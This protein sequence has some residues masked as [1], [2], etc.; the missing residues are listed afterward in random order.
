MSGSPR[1]DYPTMK[2]YPNRFAITDVFGKEL[3]LKDVRNGMSVKI[4][5]PHAHFPG[6]NWLS[7]SKTGSGEYFEILNRNIRK[8]H[9]L[10][11]K[12]IENYFLKRLRVA[13]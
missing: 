6:Y 11:G 9:A 10:V 5:A 2:D 1:Y 12:P 7:T 13:Q 4:F 3:W 8:H